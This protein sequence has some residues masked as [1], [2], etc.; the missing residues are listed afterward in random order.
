MFLDEIQ[1][2]HL[3]QHD[4]RVVGYMQDAVE[5]PTCPHYVTGS[6]MSILFKILGTGSLYGRFKDKPIKQFTDYYGAELVRKSSKYNETKI[7]ETMAPVISERCGG[8]PFY[9]NSVV[10]QSVEQGLE[11]TS[12]EAINKILAID[13]SA[14]FIYSELRDQVIKWIKRL[15]DQNITKWI[16]WWGLLRE[17]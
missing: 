13:L 2:L 17:I 1:N 3:P 12:E 9:I 15:N 8:N 5:S 16:L 11:L 14:G 10:E 4:F 7:P 6:A